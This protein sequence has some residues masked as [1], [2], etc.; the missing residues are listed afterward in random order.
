MA[1]V[2]SSLLISTLFSKV[3]IPETLSPVKSPMEVIFGWS[4]L[5]TRPFRFP[6]KFPIK[7]SALSLGA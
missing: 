6:S 3:E 2:P 1:G 7:V 4:T 5:V